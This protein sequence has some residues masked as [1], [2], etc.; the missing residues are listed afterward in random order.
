MSIVER[1]TSSVPVRIRSSLEGSPGMRQI[2]SGSIDFLPR[3]RNPNC[4][5]HQADEEPLDDNV[6]DITAYRES[7]DQGLKDELYV[8]KRI[9]EC[10]VQGI[11]Q[12]NPYAFGAGLSFWTDIDPDTHSGTTPE[13]RQK[14]KEAVEFQV[15]PTGALGEPITGDEMYADEYMKV[16][17]LANLRQSPA[18]DT[19]TEEERTNW[20][21]SQFN[22]LNGRLFGINRSGGSVTPLND[23]RFAIAMKRAFP[24]KANQIDVY[25][26]K[27]NETV[28]RPGQAL[29]VAERLLNRALK[30]NLLVEPFVSKQTFSPQAMDL[31]PGLIPMNQSEGWN[32]TKIHFNSDNLAA[33]TMMRFINEFYPKYFTNHPMDSNVLKRAKDDLCAVAKSTRMMQ[34]PNIV[35]L[36][37]EHLANIKVLERIL[38]SHSPSGQLVDL[39]MTKKASNF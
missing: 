26:I 12:K 17:A 19:L 5:M 14:L 8:T 4:R 7:K 27:Y 6:V 39:E 15:H 22:R 24:A 18:G 34:D 35:L 33:V 23:F 3:K 16:S 28:I 25:N 29:P 38:G 36:M 10:L 30:N 9:N 2:F 13:M 32:E 21:D 37:A 1:V 20:F 31:T 11:D